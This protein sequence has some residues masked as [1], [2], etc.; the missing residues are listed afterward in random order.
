MATLRLEGVVTKGRLEWTVVLI[1]SCVLILIIRERLLPE[2]E[3]LKTSAPR[4]HS[5]RAVDQRAV[6]PGVV[7]AR[8]TTLPAAN[9]G[10][11]RRTQNISEMSPPSLD[12]D[13]FSPGRHGL[14]PL[15][16]FPAEE[17]RAQAGTLELQ[18]VLMD[19]K[20]P[21]AIINDE[22]V[23]TG[24]VVGGYRVLLIAENRVVLEKGGAK[25]SLTLNRE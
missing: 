9:Q 8:E 3:S 19:R 21:L 1:L 13:L 7:N 2:K 17:V 5:A 20:N 6:S 22:V 11:T 25:R 14:N 23:G 10:T 15:G 4:S 18:A 16:I 12:R 24:Q